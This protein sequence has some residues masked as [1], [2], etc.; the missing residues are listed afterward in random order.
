MAW[1]G[2]EEGENFMFPEFNESTVTPPAVRAGLAAVMADK[3]ARATM[4]RL[5]LRRDLALVLEMALDDGVSPRTARAELQ[6]FAD[7]CNEGGTA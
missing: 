3:E 4:R 7:M 2:G 5:H 1:D 6:V